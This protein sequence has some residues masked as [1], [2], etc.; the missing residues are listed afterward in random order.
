MF[1]EDGV[2]IRVVHHGSSV[3]MR[4]ESRIGVVDP[5]GVVV[6]LPELDG[7]HVA[8]EEEGAAEERVEGRRDDAAHRRLRQHQRA[9][10]NGERLG[11]RVESAAPTQLPGRH[12]ADDELEEN[13]TMARPPTTSLMRYDVKV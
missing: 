6:P 13:G 1:V 5:L 2:Q 7:A 3:D 11:E 9:V 8:G 10:G 4:D 12:V